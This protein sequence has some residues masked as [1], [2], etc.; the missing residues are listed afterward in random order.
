MKCSVKSKYSQSIEKIFV[1]NI[2]NAIDFVEFVRF[3]YWL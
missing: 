1:Y 2:L 3:E